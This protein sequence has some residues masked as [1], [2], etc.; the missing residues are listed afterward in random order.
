MY[1]ARPIAINEQRGITLTQVKQCM[2][3]KEQF[4]TVFT[5]VG[6][7]HNHAPL[8]TNYLGISPRSPPDENKVFY[9]IEWIKSHLSIKNENQTDVWGRYLGWRQHFNPGG[10][11]CVSVQYDKNNCKAHRWNFSGIFYTSNLTGFS[12]ICL[13]FYCGGKRVN[14]FWSYWLLFR[15]PEQTCINEND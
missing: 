3:G 2:W 13:N 5:I 12:I 11:N 14:H 1:S 10:F 6:R 8:L 15:C 4:G 7:M 9:H